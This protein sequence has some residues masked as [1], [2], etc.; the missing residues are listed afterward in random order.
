M[1]RNVFVNRLQCELS[2]PKSARKVSGLSRKARHTRDAQNVCAVTKEAPSLNE[3][4][5]VV[6]FAVM[7]CTVHCGFNFKSVYETLKNNRSSESY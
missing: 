7:F 6:L 3:S 4:N 5:W 2:C 1:L